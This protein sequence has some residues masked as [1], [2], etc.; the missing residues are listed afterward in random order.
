MRQFSILFFLLV[1][2]VAVS[3]CILLTLVTLWNLKTN[4]EHFYTLEKYSW[5]PKNKYESER[6]KKCWMKKKTVRTMHQGF[7]WCRAWC[8]THT[9]LYIIIIYIAIVILLLLFFSTI[10]LLDLFI[11]IRLVYQWPLL[12]GTSISNQY[13]NNDMYILWSH[14]HSKWLTTCIYYCIVIP[15]VSHPDSL[16][17]WIVADR[18]MRPCPSVGFMQS[19]KSSTVQYRIFSIPNILMNI[20]IFE[21][22]S[23]RK[24][25]QSFYW[26]AT[27]KIWFRIRYS[28]E[29]EH[30]QTDGYGQWSIHYWLNISRRI[31]L[32][33]VQI[34]YW[35]CYIFYCFSFQKLP[36]EKFQYQLF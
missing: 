36:V 29:V 22:D 1:V 14:L 16:L 23:D 31:F 4:F 19:M 25:E 21:C 12:P 27:A 5:Q 30:H 18:A 28:S 24:K 33:T 10:F 2:V 9:Y 34:Y 3:F 13:V 32:N 20:H 17:C 15:F 6:G 26:Q 7:M 35:Y 11:F 8:V